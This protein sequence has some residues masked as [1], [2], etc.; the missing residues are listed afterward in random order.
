[1]KFLYLG[2]A[3]SDYM[4]QS[5]K[6]LASKN[7]KVMMVFTKQNL[8]LKKNEKDINKDSISIHHLNFKNFN[9]ILKKIK[10]F[11]PNTIL[12][13][14]YHSLI[15]RYFC[16]RLKSKNIVI[17]ICQDHYWT[18]SVKQI[19]GRII[20]KIYLHTIAKTVLIPFKSAGH[21]K[22]ALEMKFKK[23]NILSPLYSAD[24]QIYKYRNNNKYKNSFVFIG[25]FEHV[26]GLDILL[27]AYKLYKSK[28]SK[29]WELNIY[30]YGSLKN[31]LEENKIEG[32]NI[33][34][35]IST[36]QKV[37]ILVNTTCLIL[38]SY[39]E[40]FGV[41]VHE[42]LCSGRP[43]IISENCGSKKL[44][45]ENYNGF[46]FKKNSPKYLAN[47][48]L[49]ITNLSPKKIKKLKKNSYSSSFLINNDLW[50]NNLINY[51]NKTKD[52]LN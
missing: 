2:F 51:I 23:K 21:L 24:H 40:P 20:S 39:V 13:P 35:Q 1:M 15:F 11:K 49:K 18:G 38:P 25:R 48:M 9:T 46:I 22:W 14:N 17:I 44:I 12:I 19:I 27:K 36:N 6:K 7:N 52:N 34:N 43:V 4:V 10:K 37:K 28:T 3:S 16:F 47:K 42:A 45:K 41:V 26:K 32:V 29:P 8:I 33:Y 30:G 31:Q 50:S 5:F